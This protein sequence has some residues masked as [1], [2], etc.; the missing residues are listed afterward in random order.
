MVLPNSKIQPCH[1]ERNAY[2][3]I[4]QSTLHQVETNTMSAEQQ[5]AMREILINHG[6]SESKIVVIDSDQGHSGSSTVGR[7]GFKAL[8]AELSGPLKSIRLFSKIT[9]LR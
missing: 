3:Y 8:F 1:L 4:R 5:Y 2:L 9:T 6:W 7:S